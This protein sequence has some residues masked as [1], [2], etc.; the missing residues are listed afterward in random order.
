MKR[1]LCL[2]GAAASLALLISSG[3]AGAATAAA[4]G[5][6]HRPISVMSIRHNQVTSTN[7]SG[8]AVQASSQ[9]TQV[10]GTWVQPTATCNSGRT[11][12]AFWVGIDGYKSQSVEQLGTDSDCVGQGQPSYYAWYE[13]YPAGS[14]DVSTS[15]YPVKPGDTL[16]ASVSRA[17]TS[18]TLSISSSEGWD[19]S[20]VKSGS[21]AN[22]SAEWVIEAPEICSDVSCSLAKLSDYG[23]VDFSA[24]EAATT[25]SP[26]P[27]SSFTSNSG[28]HR[29]TMEST[30]GTVKSKPSALG[31]SGETFSATWKHS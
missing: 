6:F 31:S 10:V 2:G 3:G 1:S 25:G 15:K 23:T 20:V 29:M 30:S 22:S 21:N 24:S 4:P 5:I 8:Y 16:T 19:F 13:M 14:V 28:P 18:Y 17:G 9:F 7:W 26:A 11:Y 12:A 27:I